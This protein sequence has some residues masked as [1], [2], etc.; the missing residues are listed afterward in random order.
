VDAFLLDSININTGQVGGTGQTHD[1]TIS[2]EIARR[3][4]R[5]VILAGGLNPENVAEAIRLVAPFGVDVNSG[6][7]GAD[8]FKDAEKMRAFD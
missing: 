8:G 6:T 3:V 7:K 1:W 4:R 2:R 5:P